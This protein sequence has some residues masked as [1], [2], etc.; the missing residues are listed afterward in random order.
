VCQACMD[1]LSSLCVRS[2]QSDK[3]VHGGYTFKIRIFEYYVDVIYCLVVDL[4]LG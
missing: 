4:D 3:I 2:Y 1:F